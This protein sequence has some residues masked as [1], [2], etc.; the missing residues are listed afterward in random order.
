MDERVLAERLIT[1]DTSTPE[2]LRAAAAFVQRL[3]ANRASRRRPSASSTGCPCVL[4]DVGTEATAPRVIF[5]G[6]LDVVPAR[7]GQ[8]SPAWRATG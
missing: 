3:A 7:D 8:F 4:A 6:H 2:G 5:H 1:Y